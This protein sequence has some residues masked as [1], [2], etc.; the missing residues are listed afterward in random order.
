MSMFR[1][2][3]TPCLLGA[4]V[5]S[6]LLVGCASGLERRFHAHI[7]YLASDELEGRGVGTRGIELAADYIADE[8]RRIG[9]KPAGENGTYFQTFEMPAERRLK[10]DSRLTFS[11]GGAPLKLRT[12]FVPLG[13]SSDDAFEGEVVFCGYGIVTP[14]KQRDDFVHADVTGKVAL[15]LRGEPPSMADADGDPSR[16]AWMRNKVYN[17]K[18]RGAV[19]VLIVNQSPEEGAADSLIEFDA[20][21]PDDFGIP[22][23]HVTRAVVAPLLAGAGLPSLADLQTKLDGGAYASAALRG[24]RAGGKAEF[25]ATRVP[26]RNV[27]AMLPGRGP[28]ADE[29]VVIGAHYDHLGIRKPMERRFRGGKLVREESAPAI[30][31]GADDNASGVSGI[32]EAARLLAREKKP[33]RSVLFIAFTAE[34]SGLHGSKHFVNEPTVPLERMTAMINLDMIGRMPEGRN[35]VEVFGDGSGTGVSD[36]LHR[37]AKTLGLEVAPADDMGGRSD[38]APFIRNDIPAMHFFT[39]IH[40]DYHKPGDDTE[41]IN[42]RDGARVTRLVHL[43]ARDLAQVETRPQFVAL[44]DKAPAAAGGSPSFRVVMGLAP[45]YGDDGKPGMAVEMVSPEGPADLAGMKAGDRIVRISGKPVANIYDYMAATRSNN[46]GDVIE[47]VVLRDGQEVPL[48][49]TL[50]GAR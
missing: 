39:G 7:E 31:N 24:V 43:V 17:A 36:V 20:S 21:G 14:D 2:R 22:C 35:S 13:F 4:M 6:A 11:P 49:V 15:M 33:G 5:G 9:L 29:I 8:F 42:V 26:T 10:D 25:E 47:V 44:P 48:Q 40:E 32:I 27:L 3:T 50:A 34:E 46:P 28:L 38:H 12:D 41:K 45:G 30:H 37:N 16:H 18:D 1:M 23:L 19:A